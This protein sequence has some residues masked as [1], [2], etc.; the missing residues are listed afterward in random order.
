M[1][2]GLHEKRCEFEGLVHLRVEQR[3]GEEV[4]S[5]QVYTENYGQNMYQARIQRYS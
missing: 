3:D 4:A 2:D 1:D 5:I